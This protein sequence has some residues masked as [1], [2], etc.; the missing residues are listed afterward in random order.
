MFND[1][2]ESFFKKISHTQDGKR[3]YLAWQFCESHLK[4]QR[5]LLKFPVLVFKAPLSLSHTHNVTHVPAP[6]AVTDC[7]HAIWVPVKGAIS[8]FGTH[9]C[10][11]KKCGTE[12][13]RELCRQTLFGT[14][15]QISA[16]ALNLFK[17]VLNCLL[18]KKNKKKASDLHNKSDAHA[19][20]KEVNCFQSMLL[21]LNKPFFLPKRERPQG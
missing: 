8:Q 13:L 6:D 7:I 4:N 20:E 9:S 14:Y 16:Q 1:T 3:S 17:P 15:T 5:R 2:V 12:Y 21:Q 11:E 18:F 19:W 10:L